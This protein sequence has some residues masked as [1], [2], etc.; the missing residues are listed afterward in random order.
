MPYAALWRHRLISWHFQI[1]GGIQTV[2]LGSDIDDH[3][4][5]LFYCRSCEVSHY[6]Y[7][8]YTRLRHAVNCLYIHDW[9]QTII[10]PRSFLEPVLT[11][12]QC[13]RFNSIQITIQSKTTACGLRMRRECRERF[14]CHRGIAIPTCTTARASRT[15]RDACRDRSLAGSFEVSGGENVPGIPGACATRNFTYL[16]RGPWWRPYHKQ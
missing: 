12:N 6:V 11:L 4:N 13:G 8:D 9:S 16:I 14:S 3:G 7:I 10:T 5:I 15:C 2:S 1:V